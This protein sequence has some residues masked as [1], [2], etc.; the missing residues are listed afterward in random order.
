[1]RGRELLCAEG[2]PRA[3]SALPPEGTWR[4]PGETPAACPGRP[5]PKRMGGLKR[6]SLQR[7]CQGCKTGKAAAG[8]RPGCSQAAR[9]APAAEGEEQLANARLRLLA[10]LVGAPP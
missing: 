6:G 2:G 8:F 3:G 4:G 1:M 9:V 7:R 10:S 5:D